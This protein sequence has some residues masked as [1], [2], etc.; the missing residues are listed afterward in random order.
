MTPKGSSSHYTMD[1]LRDLAYSGDVTTDIPTDSQLVLQMQWDLGVSQALDHIKSS[2]LREQRTANMSFQQIQ[3]SRRKSS[4]IAN[5][6]SCSCSGFGS[7]QPKFGRELSR[8]V[9]F[10]GLAYTANLS[11]PRRFIVQPGTREIILWDYAVFG[12]VMYS[13][14]ATPIV[15][16]NISGSTTMSTITNA[17]IDAVLLAD[18]GI[19]FFR[20]Y[21]DDL[22]D[23]IVTSRTHIMSRYLRGWFTADLLGALP[24]DWILMAAVQTS[25]TTDLGRTL[26]LVKMIRVL[27]ILVPRD[28]V[29]ISIDPVMNPSLISLMRLVFS[30]VLMWHWTACMYWKVSTDGIASNAT[31]VFDAN[32]EWYP[33]PAVM[34]SSTVVRYLAALTWS[35]GVTSQTFRPEPSTIPQQV[36]TNVVAVVGILAMATVIGSATTVIGE[37]QAQK[38][39]TSSRLQ[40][41]ARYM[42]YMRLPQTLRRRVISFYRFQY[43][44]MS[45][46]D[47]SSVLEGLPRPLKMQMSL[48]MHSSLFVQLPLF[49]MCGERELL[50]LV[51][52]LRPCLAM[53]GEM[54]IHEGEVGVGIFF[55]MKGA[56]ETLSAGTLESVLLA[57]SA[58]GETSLRSEQA[59]V[60]ACALRFC[61]MSVL[62]RDDFR[63]VETM[64]PQ[65]QRW[66]DVYIRE[67]DGQTSTKSVRNQ[68]AVARTA[69]VRH[70]AC[71]DWITRDV[72]AES[73]A[74]KST[75]RPPSQL[76]RTGTHALTEAIAAR[77]LGGAAKRLMS[78]CEAARICA[79]RGHITSRLR[80]GS[81]RFGLARTPRPPDAK[82]PR[83]DARRERPNGAYRIP[84]SSKSDVTKSARRERGSEHKREMGEV[85]RYFASSNATASGAGVG[86]DPK[87]ASHADVREQ[88]G[89]AT[90]PRTN[91]PKSPQRDHVLDEL[92]A[93]HEKKLSRGS[94]NGNGLATAGLA[95]L[96]A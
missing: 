91:R 17:L 7:N 64:N 28:G 11:K 84:S 21:E 47:E 51:Q 81:G 20:A 25:D 27:H 10:E 50:F 67:R 60:T 53:P 83:E 59:R 24:L 92:G 58:F 62:L 56:V 69:S 48:V 70:R 30:L 88:N 74:F 82:P 52:R 37:I 4:S 46:I 33:S 54:L 31:D 90:R 85:E 39:E 95:Y 16:C 6:C 9:S 43:T 38:A 29:S 22:R 1:E 8:R 87:P 94:C 75:T 41:I 72:G 61:E 63:H 89:T 76:K 66:L 2:Q 42:R 86:G 12:M 35:I 34:N 77:Q 93:I 13:V 5:R 45:L 14:F 40:R 19:T 49:W 44:S 71:R 68:S 65:I 26:R 79:C 18:V 36:F 80:G 57:I 55:L 32:H 23:I 3:N 78:S 96:Q 73:G 15:S